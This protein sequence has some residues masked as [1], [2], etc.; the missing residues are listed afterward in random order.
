MNATSQ[1]I[2]LPKM[3]LNIPEDC[4]AGSIKASAPS[5]VV[6]GDKTEFNNDGPSVLHL[7]RSLPIKYEVTKENSPHT[8]CQFSLFVTNGNKK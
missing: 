1:Q 4:F 6:A 7:A 3:Y 5:N 8:C 2:T